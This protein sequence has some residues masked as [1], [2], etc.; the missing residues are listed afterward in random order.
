MGAA[1]VPCIATEVTARAT[2]LE[3]SRVRLDVQVDPA[4]LERAVAGAARELGREMRIPGFRQGKVPPQVVV[5]RMGRE[6]VLD[7]AVR[8]ALPGWYER[9]V[10]DAGLVT[11][12]DP[13]LDMD[14]PPERGNPLSFTVEVGVRPRAKLGAY[15]GLEVGRRLPDVDSTE[16]DA[17]VERLARLRRLARDR[18]RLAAIGDYVTV[19]FLGSIDG[20]PFEGGEDA[21]RARARL[22]SVR[23][24][25]RGRPRG[26]RGRRG[27]SRSPCASPTTT[28]PSTRGR[29][30]VFATTVREVKEKRLPELDDD[31]A[32]DA[33]GFESMADLRADVEERIREA[34]AQR[35]EGEFREAVV[36]AAVAQA[37]VDVPQDLV[38]A[39]AHEM[40]GHRPPPARPGRR[41]RALRPGHGK[42][43]HDLY[44]RGAARSRY[45]PEARE[46]ARRRHRRRGHRGLGRR[47]A[48]F[49]RAR[50]ATGLRAAPGPRARAAARLRPG[51]R[52][53]RAGSTC[54]ART[55]PCAGRWTSRSRPSRSRSTRRAPARR[56]GRRTRR[57]SGEG[58]RRPGGS[59]GPRDGAS[60]SE[61]LH[62][63]H[64]GGPLEHMAGLSVVEPVRPTP[65]AARPEAVVGPGA[66]DRLGPPAT[67]RE[68][69]R[70]RR[71][72]RNRS[73]S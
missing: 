60:R 1:M 33:G 63:Q 11:V 54:C 20:E 41:P 25:L 69:G 58:P 64:G 35:I 42:T 68:A 32:A 46:R 53:T 19:D 18:R 71:P 24:R 59:C 12:G 50:P 37:E 34:H 8:R 6:A 72:K 43:V 55:S 61:R 14:E 73:E 10:H 7:E 62:V 48:R 17:D 4:V 15:K 66:V 51:A 45:R 9:A 5:Q 40:G 44:R 49:R 70:I 28:R 22:G 56:C 30:A 39:K 67:S 26:R 31:F 16:I 27:A 29:D 47:G 36:D 3:D 23:A 13:K 57:T 38:H 21:A 2:E 52:A 65:A